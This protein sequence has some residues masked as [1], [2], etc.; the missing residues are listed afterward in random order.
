MAGILNAA[1][2]TGGVVARFSDAELERICPFHHESGHFSIAAVSRTMTLYGAQRGPCAMSVASE[3]DLLVHAGIALVVSAAHYEIATR[4]RWPRFPDGYCDR[5]STAVVL[6][7]LEHGYA[8]AIVLRASLPRDHSYVAL[9]YALGQERGV[10]IA[11]PTFG[12][13]PGADAAVLVTRREGQIWEYRPGWADG[14]DL[15]PDMVLDKDRIR[16]L[17]NTYRVGGSLSAEFGTLRFANGDNERKDAARYLGAAFSQLVD[18]PIPSLRGEI[19]KKL[20]PW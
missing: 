3:S 20:A 16:L 5:S 6:S 10:V 13:M 4:E 19:L 17:A 18:V 8:N 15:Y 12:Q 11:D 1:S 2:S 9:P 14:A 7:L